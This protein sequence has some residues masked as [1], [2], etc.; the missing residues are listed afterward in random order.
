MRI[1][2]AFFLLALS[3]ANVLA[4]EIAGTWRSDTPR[5]RALVIQPGKSGYHGFYYL[6]ESEAAG[7]AISLT[8]SKDGKVTF[9]LI[10]RYSV[11]DGKIS[12]DGKMLSGSWTTLQGTTPLNFTR[13]D[14]N[15]KF[16]P[17]PHR[18]LRIEVEKSVS[19][20]VLDFGG[21]GK[22]LVFI[23]GS[24]NTAHI[25]DAFAPK[26]TAK[27]HVYAITRRGWGESDIPPATAENYDADRMGDDVLAV[28]AALKIEKPVLIGHSFAGE[29][30]SSI[31][32]RFPDRVSGLIYLDAGYSYAFY[33]PDL[34]LSASVEA[35]S[36]RRKLA[37]L[38]NLQP[39]QWPAATRDISD[40]MARLNKHMSYYDELAAGLKDETNPKA[41]AQ[42]STQVVQAMEQGMH[43]YTGI[44]P[45]ILVIYATPKP[46]APACNDPDYLR[47]TRDETA[48]ADVVEKSYP[49]GRVV[50]IPRANHYVFRSHEAEVMKEVN[51]F[52]DGVGQ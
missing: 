35:D 17:A 48:Q 16:D 38:V 1:L 3:G 22:P 14:P 8:S 25:F 30:M 46:C 37:A 12:A 50:R 6:L 34:E 39:S 26:F 36:L 33:N 52:L 18:A 19:L 42:P 5:P 4:A 44:K 15:W 47:R 13:A 41:F 28:L 32:T 45:P 9:K 10:P 49:S 20:E 43:A 23:P 27:H 51:T 7:T 24:G 29:E 31:G 2:V 40:S 11:F 21:T